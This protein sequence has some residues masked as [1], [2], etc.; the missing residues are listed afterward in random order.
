M[1]EN[2]GLLFAAFA[3][4]QGI[5]L[6]TYWT[7]PILAGALITGLELT[8]TEVGLIGTIEF[9]GLLASSLVL[10]P[11]I[12]R[13]FRKA[14][15]LLSISIVIGANLICAFV[16]LDYETLAIMRFICG[17]GSGLALAVGNATIANAWDAE[18]FSSHLTLAL[19]A[20][21]VLI[22]PVFSR[23]S[24]QFGQQ[25]VFLGLA[26]TVAIGAISIIFLPNG[27]NKDLGADG[28]EGGSDTR[29]TVRLLTTTAV[30]V[31]L[32]AV[33]FGVRDTLPWLVAEQ[34]GADAGLSL[35]EIG[36]LFSTMYAVSIL[37]PI[38]MLV[39]TRIIEPKILLAVSMTATGLFAWM[40]TTSDGNA[41]QFST[42]IIIWAT[43]YFVAFAQLNAVAAII[44]RTGR[45][46][47]AVGSAFIAGV[48]AGPV[49]GGVL[50]DRGGY[51]SIG[52]AEL[53]FTVLIA[54]VVIFGLKLNH[55]RSIKSE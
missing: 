8:G 19:V 12:D 31:L 22:M 23:L 13:G 47:S 9:A 28:H 18:K 7:L 45:L 50:L 26:V 25:G 10:A 38:S 42:G 2:W 1:P 52:Y 48:M 5:G 44:D 39:L 49:I 36:N 16:A 29:V 14:V 41:Q 30:M 32:I 53:A 51:S 3:F 11:F 37:G 21:M 34:L 15:A 33:L 35:P 43:I 6:I 20:F 54:I 46:V 40:F 55:D 24:E 27:P 17:L 4:S